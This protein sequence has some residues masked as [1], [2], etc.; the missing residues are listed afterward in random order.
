VDDAV[1]RHAGTQGLSLAQRLRLATLPL[2]TRLLA[3]ACAGLERPAGGQVPGRAELIRLALAWGNLGYAAGF[4][5][6]RHVS[7]RALNGSG[8][9]LECGSGA[10]TL[11]V[12]ALTRQRDIRF[13][14]LE[15][16]PHWHAYL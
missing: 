16:D 15:H 10:T 14:A 11:L 7:D 9:V 6:L 1:E 8:P 3:H 5:Y 12:A 2:K 4:S 13:V